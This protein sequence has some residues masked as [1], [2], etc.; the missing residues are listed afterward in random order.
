MTTY[1]T[2]APEKVVLIDRY[3]RRRG[4]LFFTPKGGKMPYV[5]TEQAVA[6]INKT[7]ISVARQLNA[8]EGMSSPYKI[9]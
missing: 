8:R 5:F 3:P 1:I 9:F 4:G 7:R 6:V 2:P